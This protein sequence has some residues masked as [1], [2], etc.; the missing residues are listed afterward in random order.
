[1][2][3]TFAIEPISIIFA[4]SSFAIWSENWENNV[5]EKLLRLTYGFL[6]FKTCSCQGESKV[7]IW[8]FKIK[9]RIWSQLEIAETLSFQK[10]MRNFS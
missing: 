2:E 7:V 6:K 5:R 1:M 9:I 4:E 3:Q 10:I 8:T